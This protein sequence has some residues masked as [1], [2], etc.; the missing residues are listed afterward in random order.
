MLSMDL[1]QDFCDGVS[2]TILMPLSPSMFD[3]MN[4]YIVYKTDF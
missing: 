1:V 4:S 3:A 2:R